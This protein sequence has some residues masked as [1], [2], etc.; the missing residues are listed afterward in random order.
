MVLAGHAYAGAVIGA[1]K[2]DRVK[3]LVYIAALAPE[4]G[5]TVGKVFYRDKPHPDAPKLTPD[6][7]GF[8]WM[9]EEGF[10]RAV[11]HNASPDQKNIWLQCSDQLR[12]NAFKSRPRHRHGKRN[13][14][15]F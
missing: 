5:E 3:S 12:F 10:R 15:G 7:H 9:P 8:I 11:A 1:Y 2:E 14:R 4:E 13:R 6:K